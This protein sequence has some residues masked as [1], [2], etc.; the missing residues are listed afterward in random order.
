MSTISTTF[1]KLTSSLSKNDH[2]LILT[3]L[4]NDEEYLDHYFQLI[5][6]SSYPNQYISIGLLVSD[7]T[8]NTLNI[9][10][11]KVHSLQN[12][13]RNRFYEIDVYQK[14]FELDKKKDEATALTSK[15]ATLAKAKNFLLTA[16]LREHHSW[17]AWVDVKLFSY[18]ST[19]YDDLK[20]VN[21][22]VIVPNCLQKREKDDEFWAF[23]RNNWQESEM[24][25]QRQQHIPEEDLLM[26]DYNEY[27]IGRHLLVDMPTHGN[28][29]T[30]VPLDGIGGTFTLVKA[31]VHREGAIFPP[32]VY[33]HNMDTEGFAK[34]VKSM[35]YS[36][37][38]VPS[39]IIYHY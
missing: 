32:F 23:D 14:D 11:E 10:Q 31:N 36:V 38:G 9:L 12:R 3:L 2:I 15:R 16:A 26:E 27:A 18:P 29:E 28:I 21:V 7:S 24:S 25:L 30:K 22:D 4:Q 34:M 20:A 33:Q 6:A 8:D 17:V 35:G 1:N 19:I 37:Y 39:Y 13:W 5:D